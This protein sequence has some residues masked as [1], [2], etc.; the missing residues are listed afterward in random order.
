MKYI[1]KLQSYVGPLP[2]NAVLS[3]RQSDLSFLDVCQAVTKCAYLLRVQKSFRDWCL[4]PGTISTVSVPSFCSGKCP[5]WTQAPSP[6]A[7][8]R[9]TLQWELYGLNFTSSQLN[10]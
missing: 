3:N 10:G 6:A 2:K 5:S 4:W 7:G 8:L 1:N 9:R